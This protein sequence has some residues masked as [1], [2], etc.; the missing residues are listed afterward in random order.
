MLPLRTAIKVRKML[1][2]NK[3]NRLIEQRDDI[4]N[5]MKKALSDDDMAEYHRL[6]G[7]LILKEEKIRKGKR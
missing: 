3:Y 7:R 6:N 4:R 1:A 2:K 5:A